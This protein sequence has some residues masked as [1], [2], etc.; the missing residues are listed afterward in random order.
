MLTKLLPVGHRLAE[1]PFHKIT[2][3]ASHLP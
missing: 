1:L 2:I 3:V